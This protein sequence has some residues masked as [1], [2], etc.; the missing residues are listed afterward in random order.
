MSYP[1]LLAKVE[2]TEDCDLIG[3]DVTLVLPGEGGYADAGAASVTTTENPTIENDRDSF[4]QKGCR[5]AGCHAGYNEAIQVRRRRGRQW[6][7]RGAEHAGT[8]NCRTA[9]QR[10]PPDDARSGGLSEC[11]GQLR[12]DHCGQPRG[13]GPGPSPPLRPGPTDR[14]RRVDRRR[15]SRLSGGERNEVSHASKHA[16]RPHRGRT[17][18]FH[19][20]VSQDRPRCSSTDFQ[21]GVRSPSKIIEFVRAAFRG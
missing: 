21:S 12:Y 14:T 16:R 5:P 11:R 10:W 18:H 3:R 19:G 17:G 2:Y 15:P 6:S 13:K 1:A 4:G 9:G 20:P 7:A 8:S